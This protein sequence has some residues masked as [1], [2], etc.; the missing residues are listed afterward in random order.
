MIKKLTKEIE[1][2][3]GSTIRWELGKKYIAINVATEE[4]VAIYNPK[5]DTLTY[6][7]I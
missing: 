2:K 3:V 5:N 7:N 4:V 1:E 6:T